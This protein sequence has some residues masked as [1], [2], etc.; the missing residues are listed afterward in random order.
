MAA[1]ADVEQQR[2]VAYSA[3]QAAQVAHARPAFAGLG[4]KRDPAACRLQPED[5]A[6]RRRNPDGPAAVRRVGERH[7]AAGDRRGRTAARAAGRTIPAARV[8]GRSMGGGLGDQRYP[9]LAAVGPPDDDRPS[10]LQPL[11]EDAVVGPLRHVG[12]KGAPKRRARAAARTPEVLQQDRHAAKRALRQALAHLVARCVGGDLGH[13][14]QGRIDLRHGLQAGLQ[15]LFGRDLAPGDQP[16]DVGR[17]EFGVSAHA[18][19]H[20]VRGA[21]KAGAD[22]VECLVRGQGVDAQPDIAGSR[23]EEVRHAGRREPTGQGLAA[24]WPRP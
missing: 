7:H 13:R 23:A 21:F 8:A 1:K 18:S 6:V 10:L 12:E 2:A 17:I 24:V 11:D 20:P 14:I 15:D 19:A 5:A 22:C 16:S 3:R 9:E 4:R